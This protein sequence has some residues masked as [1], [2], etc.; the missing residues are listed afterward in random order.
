MK[1]LIIASG[2]VGLLLGTG[3]GSWCDGWRGERYQAVGLGNLTVARLDTKTGEMRVFA[4]ITEP[5]DET[6]SLSLIG[7]GRSFEGRVPPPE[8]KVVTDRNAVEKCV[9]LGHFGDKEDAER[10]SASGGDTLYRGRSKG[11]SEQVWLY[12]CN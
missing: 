12:R 4:P 6:P 9:Y 5:S 3:L 2:L 8:V 11:G 7:V 1:G 10:A